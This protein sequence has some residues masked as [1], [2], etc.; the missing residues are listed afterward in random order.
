[1]SIEGTMVKRLKVIPDERGHLME[2][3]RSDDPEFRRFGQAYITT[4]FPGVVK[5]WHCH[6]LQFDNLACIKGQVKLALYDGRAGSPSYGNIQTLYMGEHQSL[7]V[8][9]PPGVYHGF[10][11][12]GA[13][14][15][16]VFNCPTEPYNTIEPDE[17]RLPPDDPG[18]GYDWSLRHG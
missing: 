1:M 11:G 9:V 10:K 17:L 18:I 2:I 3:L 6:R 13:E 12:I 16:I 7:L 8:H 5:A 4:V 15:A 14:E